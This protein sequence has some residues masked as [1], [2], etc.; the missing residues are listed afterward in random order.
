M[1]F[2]AKSFTV[3]ALTLGFLATVTAVSVQAVR[4]SDGR[5]AFNRPPSLV[6]ATT[7]DHSSVGDGRF[8]FVIE[9]PA[10]AGEPL[11]AVVITPLDRAERIAFNLDGSEAQLS[12]AYAQGPMVPLASVG[13][14]A[15]GSGD[16][17]VVFD[18]PVQPGETVTVTLN[19][20]QNPRA[21]VYQ[22]EVTGY[23]A[24]DNG[25]GQY[26]GVGRISI[27]DPSN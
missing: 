19:T 23:P 21:G 15:D 13:G 27:F 3:S 9:V 24:G 4:F 7:L 11:G 17:L 10:D 14:A 6:E 5:V 1:N 22:F 18:E 16:M 25:V 2:K 8:H 12:S 26:L 20:V